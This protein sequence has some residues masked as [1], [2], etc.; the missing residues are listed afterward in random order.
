VPEVLQPEEQSGLVMRGSSVHLLGLLESGGL[1]YGFE[2][3]SVSRQHGLE[4][5]ALPPEIDLRDEAH[6]ESYARVRVS[7]A[8]Q[9]FASVNP[10]FRGRPIAYGITIP[11]NAPHPDP[12][13][14]FIQFLVG[15]EGQAVIAEDEHPMIIPPVVGHR[16]PSPMCFDR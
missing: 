10:E 3:E 5:L 6:P 1:D 8:F 9:C 4:F 2:Y 16:S 7:L 14:E 11:N 15:P 13:V 12:A